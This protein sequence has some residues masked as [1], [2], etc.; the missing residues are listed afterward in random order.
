MLLPDSCVGTSPVKTS[1]SIGA[2]NI[3]LKICLYLQ[4]LIHELGNKC[5]GKQLLSFLYNENKVFF[6]L[7]NTSFILN[8]TAY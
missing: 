5:I 6:N 4:C 2:V 8:E 7:S 1:P 3:Y